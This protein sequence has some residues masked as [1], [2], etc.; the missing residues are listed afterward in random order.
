MQQITLTEFIDSMVSHGDHIV[1]HLP[2]PSTLAR[3]R[4]LSETIARL[5]DATLENEYLGADRFQVSI[6]HPSF[7]VHLCV[8]WLC[9]SV[10][11]TPISASESALNALVDHAKTQ[12]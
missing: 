4:H 1:L 8:E 6:V 10:W 5:L 7:A 2:L 9:E 11:L 12:Q 3:A